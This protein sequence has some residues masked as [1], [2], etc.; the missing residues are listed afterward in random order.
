MNHHDVDLALTSQS[1]TEAISH[2]FSPIRSTSQAPSL[3]HF[4][5]FCLF[6]SLQMITS[7]MLM[8]MGFNQHA[9]RSGRRVCQ[10]FCRIHEVVR[11]QNTTA[12]GLPPPSSQDEYEFDESNPAN[13]SI[14]AAI[15]SN[16]DNGNWDASSSYFTN[17][18]N[19]MQQQQIMQRQHSSAGG[20]TVNQTAQTSS[21]SSPSLSTD[22]ST[23]PVQARRP[24]N[25]WNSSLG[26]GMH[27]FYNQSAIDVAASKV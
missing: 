1:E 12:S 22:S 23:K 24:S 5:F 3:S 4:D 11:H 16:Q 7:N 21:D 9:I 25:Y 17:I 13:R 19:S 20:Q 18:R 2:F 8:M 10:Q 6:L 27:W 14:L 26:K 15:E